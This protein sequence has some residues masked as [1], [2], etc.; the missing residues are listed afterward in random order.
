[1]ILNPDQSA[2]ASQ[3][4]SGLVELSPESDLVPGLARAWDLSDDG[5][6]Y[7][8]HLRRDAVWSDGAP[9]TA[10]DFEFAWKRVLHP[11]TASPLAEQLYDIQGAQAFHQ[12]Q[13]PH[14][15]AVGVRAIDD[16][17]LRVD[18]EEPVGYFLHLLTAVVT[19][20]VPRHVVET[21]G[22]VWSA[23]EHIASNGPFR[24]DTWRPGETI[25][26]TRNPTYFGVFGGNLTQVELTLSSSSYSRI[27]LQQYLEDQ[28]DVCQLSDPDV[29]ELMRQQHADEY[30]SLP[31]VATEYLGFDTTRPPFD[32]AR[33]R[34]A[35]AHAVDRRTLADVV[36]RGA[37]APAIGGFVP[38]GLAGHSPDI[39]L[40][41]DPDHARQMLAEAG[42]PDGRGFPLIEALTI[43]F[44]EIC[45]AAQRSVAEQ[46]RTHLGVSIEWQTMESTAYYKRLHDATPQLFDAGWTADYPDPDHFLRP[47]MYGPYYRWRS[48]ELD[49]LLQAAHRL[50][51]AAERLKFYQAADRLV[52]DEAVI[53]PWGYRQ[54]H[55]LL[56]PW[57]KRYPLSPLR[58]NYWKDVI[59]EPH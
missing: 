2:I 24:L 20:A 56:K 50:S 6:R 34:R 5:R 3:L 13:A 43:E 58:D 36:L 25:V 46:W 10:Y 54:R 38:P 11:A 37:V 49:R 8:F 29:I 9:V 32:D 17:T 28:L 53:V 44:D 14:A 7:V 33:V 21:H 45:R 41:Y 15:D 51:D 31:I 47:T 48:D 39:G 16:F 19:A 26:L 42:F 27:M 57:V 40:A 23:V 59:I 12:S 55:L 18:L 22:D 35:L 1:M 30:R 52:I 4:F